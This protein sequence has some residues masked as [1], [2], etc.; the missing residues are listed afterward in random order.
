M[1]FLSD[2]FS[3]KSP[4]ES[5][6][7]PV[8][9]AETKRPGYLQPRSFTAPA[10]PHEVMPVL[11]AGENP[12][13][14]RME[15]FPQERAT[16]CPSRPI[17]GLRSRAL[18]GKLPLGPCSSPSVLDTEAGRQPGLNRA[19]ADLSVDAGGDGTRGR[20][21]E[22]ACMSVEC[23]LAPSRRALSLKWSGCASWSADLIRH[24]DRGMKA[25]VEV[26]PRAA[27]GGPEPS[28]SV[29]AGQR[30]TAKYFG[31]AHQRHKWTSR[32][33]LEVP[34]PVLALGGAL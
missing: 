11:F 25:A 29:W 10:T 13:S 9:R 2:L 21:K 27:A 8:A 7:K 31:R 34:R 14:G 33:C 28:R 15:V 32:L 24:R 26:S 3:P 19:A 18:A 22:G 5:A 4:V 30:D 17:L 6:R 20:Y 12:T 23:M 16:S 1:G